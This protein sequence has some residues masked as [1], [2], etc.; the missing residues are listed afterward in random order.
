MSETFDERQ[1]CENAETYKRW[2][3]CGFPKEAMYNDAGW[4][5]TVLRLFYPTKRITLFDTKTAEASVEYAQL[6]NGKWV[7]SSCLMTKLGNFYGYGSAVSIYDTQYDTK[8]EA[9]YAELDNIE[10]GFR[11]AD[12]KAKTPEVETALRR[13]KNEFG[14]ASVFDA[15]FGAGASFEQTSLFDVA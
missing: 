13:Y 6:P 2:L 14:N 11:Q 12:K 4:M 7:A 8:A 15:F 1:K 5:E 10:D 9:I 3:A